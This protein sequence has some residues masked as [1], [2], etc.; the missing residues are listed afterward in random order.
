MSGPAKPIVLWG[1]AGQARVL[2][3]FLG[4]AGFEPIAFF[5]NDTAVRSPLSGVPIHHGREGF[6]EW[7][8]RRGG[9]SVSFAV[10]VGGSRSRERREIQTMLEQAGLYTTI[11]VHPTAYV[12]HDASIGRGTQILARATIGA[13][14]HVGIAPPP[15]SITN[16]ILATA[17]I[18]APE[19]CSP[20]ACARA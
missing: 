9:D 15:P 14:A 12:A 4:D 10:A 18:S 11:L 6:R 17:R 19:R 1:A 5:D 8:R 20:A 7:Q 16:A 2:C 13:A 3:E